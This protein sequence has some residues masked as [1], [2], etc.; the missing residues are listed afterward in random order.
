M[1]KKVRKAKRSLRP[2]TGGAIER[3]EAQVS[4]LRTD[5]YLEKVRKTFKQLNSKNPSTQNRHEEY[6]FEKL[7][8][9]CRTPD[10]DDL[11]LLCDICDDAFH[12]FCLVNKLMFLLK[13]NLNIISE[14][15][16]IGRTT[17]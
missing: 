11:L 10:H 15:S 5:L 3:L 2:T 17:R 16:Y 13:L 12:S 7:C 14:G 4:K 9:H 8:E 6:L 1:K